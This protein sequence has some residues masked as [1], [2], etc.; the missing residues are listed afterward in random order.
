MKNDVSKIFLGILATVFGIMA[1]FFGVQYTKMKNQ[2]D[3]Y[4][5]QKTE[6]TNEYDELTAEFDE[7]SQEFELIKASS[8]ELD[9]ELQ[10]K[11]DEVETTK[12]EVSRLLRKDKLTRSE[13][14]K[15][16]KMLT[17]LRSEKDNL[18][19]TIEVLN[20][21]NLALKYEKQELSKTLSV[22]NTERV[23]ITAERDSVITVTETLT[24]EKSE[25]EDN[26]KELAP[27]A[28][29]GSVIHVNGMLTEGVRYKNSGKEVDTR[30][31]NKV[32]KIKVC[33]NLEENPV[34][35]AGDQEY[36][37]RIL[38]P[39]GV[40]IFEEARGSGPFTGNNGEGM[41]Y[42]TKTYVNYENKPKSVCL[43]WAQNVPFQE[44]L[45]T[46]EVYHHGF[47]VATQQFELR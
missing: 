40:T 32:E 21:E 5:E 6:V 13:L 3:S 17:E 47:K 25:L 2:S 7:L 9:T 15:A 20:Q 4:L 8:L 37:V 26:V 42:T 38:S 24:T 33:F 14:N 16:R 30:N 43:Y 12:N 27:K 10:A 34:A 45:Y 29:Y 36:L 1:L 35:E 11:I 46:A 22:V 19:A 41:K 31:A 18:V 28:E 39:E 23:A 44:G